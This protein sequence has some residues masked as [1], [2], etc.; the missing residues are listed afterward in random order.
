MSA[1]GILVLVWIVMMF[2][3]NIHQEKMEISQ[4]QMDAQ[5]EAN[6]LKRDEIDSL[7]ELH[8]SHEGSTGGSDV[9]VC[10]KCGYTETLAE[11]E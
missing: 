9:F 5:L 1:I 7:A 11:G 3:R 10:Q 2:F 6:E 8:C 4:K